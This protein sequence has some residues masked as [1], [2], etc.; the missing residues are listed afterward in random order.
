MHKIALQVT[1]RVII[2]QLCVKKLSFWFNKSSVK[3]IRTI[4]DLQMLT[5][6]SSMC[7]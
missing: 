7:D 6:I 5:L 2:T 4:Y 3:N 1:E